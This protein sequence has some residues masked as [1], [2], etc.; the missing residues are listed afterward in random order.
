MERGVAALDIKIAGTVTPERGYGAR[1]ANVHA[2]DARSPRLYF[3]LKPG[4]RF[5]QKFLPPTSATLISG[6][7]KAVLNLRLARDS[8]PM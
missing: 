3:E 6:E 2:Q 4:T 7:F 8:G 5:G 1:K